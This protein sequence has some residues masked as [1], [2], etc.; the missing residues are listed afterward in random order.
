MEGKKDK[1][2]KNKKK[3]R[4]I[5]KEVALQVEVPIDTLN[6]LSLPKPEPLSLEEWDALMRGQRELESV[7]KERLRQSIVEGINP[8]I[9][10]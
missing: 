6:F 5:V 2:K 8:D 1:K 10:G 9:R 3:S 7:S 4:S